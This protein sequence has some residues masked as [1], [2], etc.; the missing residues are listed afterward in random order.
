M[1]KY[2]NKITVLDGHKFDSLAESKYYEQLKW[3]RQAKQI[4]S[5][6]LQP[7]Y[8]LQEAFKKNGRTIRKIEYVA[9]FEVKH[10]DGS[11]EVIDCKGVE[12]EAFK[13]KRK[14]FDRLYLY[15]LSVISY[16]ENLGFIELDKLKKLKRKAVKKGTKRSV[17]KRPVRR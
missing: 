17:R 2:G 16:D 1:S 12:T 8:L 4:K 13:L 10:L 11:I 7:R 9:D 3:L 15:R 14:W 6:K 5:F